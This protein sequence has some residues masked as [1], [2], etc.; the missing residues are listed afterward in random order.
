MIL[1]TVNK[2]HFRHP[3]LGECLAVCGQHDGIL[4]IEDG[5]YSA[6]AIESLAIAADITVYAL[7]A[8]IACRGIGGQL[9]ARVVTVSDLD[10][11]RLS[12]EYDK[13]IAWY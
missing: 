12:T 3:C 1:H 9:D 4:L 8:D 2:S 10:F 7:E 6:T 13:V 5:V 11:V